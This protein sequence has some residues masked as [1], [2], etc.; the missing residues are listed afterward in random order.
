M[1]EQGCQFGF[2][3]PGFEFLSNDIIIWWCHCSELFSTCYD[4]IVLS[5]FN[6]LRFF[7]NQ[8]QPEKIWLFSLGK[9]WLS[10]KTLPEQHSFLS[11]YWIPVIWWVY[12]ATAGVMLKMF[13]T[14]VRVIMCKHLFCNELWLTIFVLMRCLLCL[15]YGPCVCNKPSLLSLQLSFDVSLGVWLCRV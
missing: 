3:K 13:F 2:L 15:Q 1:I 7:E 6:A 9:A 11:H 14:S 5:F 8:K 10:L 12:D 4:V